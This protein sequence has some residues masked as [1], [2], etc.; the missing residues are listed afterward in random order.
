[1][2][3]LQK[4]QS[5][6]QDYVLDAKKENTEIVNAIAG[7]F[8]LPV[9]DRLSIYYD[10][11]RLRLAEALSEEFGKTHSYV[12]D[13]LFAELC[14]SYIEKNPSRYRNLR[15]YG[16]GFAAHVAEALPDYPM[17]AELAGFE[18]ALGLAF[19]AADAPVLTAADLQNLTEDDWEQV[20][21]SLT[22]S[23]QTLAMHWNAP[24]IWLALEKEEAP[25]DAVQAEQAV[26]WLVWRH[27][28]RPHFRSINPYEAEA[29]RGLGKG[30]SFAGVC[31][32]V[33][34][35]SDEDITPQ[36]AGWL[37]VWM[38]E[39]ILSTVSRV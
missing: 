28:L 12:G 13:D 22:P 31:E 10:A 1:M 8:G 9:D 30:E 19:D 5:D 16:D 35:S 32:Q 20:G 26:T 25:P 24:G 14:Q 17:V 34:E 36:I 37:H 11:Y 38:T 4:I 7:G 39:A 21:F 29:L 18:W 3:L 2:I 27:E 15:W 23:L 6:F 33:A